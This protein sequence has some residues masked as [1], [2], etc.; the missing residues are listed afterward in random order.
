MFAALILQSCGSSE[1]TLLN[2]ARPV[3]KLNFEG[4]DGTNASAVTY[5][6]KNKLYYSGIAGNQSF[7]IAVFST[8]GKNIDQQEAGWDLRGLWYNPSSNSLEGNSYNSEGIFTLQLDSRG[9]FEGYAESV[10][11][12][13]DQPSA[14]AVGSYDYDLDEILYLSSDAVERYSRSDHEYVGLYVLSKIPASLDEI[15]YTTVAYTGVKGIE[16]CLLNFLRNEIY[17]FD[18]STGNY[19][20]NI[21]LPESAVTNESFRFSF[22]NKYLFLYD[23][24][25]R[26]WTGYKIFE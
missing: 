13:N 25:E 11:N 8:D 26:E 9:L 7:P 19:V 1:T 16:L 5:N 15:N 22:A 2:E 17:F 23:I 18:K 24:N 6:E 12:Y 14:N 10:F 3:L 4:Y 20:T 21:K